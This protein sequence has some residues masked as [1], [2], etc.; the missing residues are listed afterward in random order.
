[1]KKMKKRVICLVLAA[2]CLAL[3]A[4]TE[5]ASPT[6]AGFELKGK[7]YVM[8]P[9]FSVYGVSRG[10]KYAALAD[11]T[12]YE[13]EFEDPA[14]FLCVED[15]GELLVYR[16]KGLA[17]ITLENFHPV[18]AFV[19]DST[20]TRFIAQFF[21]NDEYLPEELRGQNDTQDTDLCVEIAHALTTGEAVEVPSEEIL[22]SNRYFIRLLSQ[23]YPGLY[24]LVTFYGD[25]NGRF[26]LRD[27]AAG[28]TVVCPRKVLARMIG[29]SNGDSPVVDPDESGVISA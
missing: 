2:A 15:S 27:R 14:R 12:L 3:C 28:K 11:E 9:A 23:D 8:C 25:S 5:K 24:Y 20:N 22:M 18:A 13:I 16:A 10:E 29:G 17:E 4:C 21:A 19:Y 26:Y 7:E 6:E 1:M